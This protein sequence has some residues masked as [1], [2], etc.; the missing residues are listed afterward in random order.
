MS[1]RFRLA[2]MPRRWQIAV[3]A[4]I[5]VLAMAAAWGWRALSPTP[6]SPPRYVE[7]GHGAYTLPRPD[8]IADFDLVRHDGRPFTN[9]ALTGRWTFLVFG[10]TYCPDFCPTT[11][12]VFNQIHG[13]L[14]RQPDGGREVQFVMVTV[15]PERDTAAQIAA[16][17]PQFNPA[18]IGVTGTKAMIGRLADS[19][20]ADHHRHAP[21]SG[22][23]YLIDHST[24]VLLV[25]PQGRVQGVFAP[26]HDA[27]DMVKAFAKIR[28]SAP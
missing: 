21:D 20:G 1:L 28:A 6:A 17:V 13:L 24:A 23:N 19:V 7:V 11:L 25:N 26:Q 10:Y 18:F 4:G 5:V 3:A 22:G 8:P 27:A 15:D 16:Y 9:G 12:A 2:R 14:A